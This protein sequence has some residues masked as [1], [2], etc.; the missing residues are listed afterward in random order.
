MLS[1]PRQLGGVD[2]YVVHAPNTLSYNQNVLQ[3][4][5]VFDNPTEYHRP[6]C[7]EFIQSHLAGFISNGIKIDKEGKVT[8][9]GEQLSLADASNRMAN[10]SIFGYCAGSS[11]SHEIM[12]CFRKATNQVYDY[13]A[14]KILD[15]I[16]T[17]NFAITPLRA[18]PATN[19]RIT[20]YNV[21]Y[22][23]LLR[24]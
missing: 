11:A 8:D 22:T 13:K 7:G 10:L 18:R 1:D 20:S 2:L 15:N 23:K 21:C 9:K 4:M 3:M 5:H 19:G 24:L 17:V 16:F 14:P 12:N 6:E